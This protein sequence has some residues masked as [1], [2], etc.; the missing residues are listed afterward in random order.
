MNHT[1]SYL[2]NQW[3]EGKS[4]QPRVIAGKN[5]FSINYRVLREDDFLEKIQVYPFVR[6]LIVGNVHL[7]FLSKCVKSFLFSI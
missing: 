6:E 7:K 4:S 3:E 2:F 1:N 5:K